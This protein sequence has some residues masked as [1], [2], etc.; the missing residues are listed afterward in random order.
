M[1]DYTIRESIPEDSPQLASLWCNIFGDPPEL[2]KSFLRLLPDMGHCCVAE[3]AGCVLGAAYLV[4]GFTLLEP[5][6]IPRRCGYLYAVAVKPDFRDM[7]IGASVSCGA[8]SL[9]RLHGAELL[10]TLPA[11]ASLYRWYDDILS[12]QYRITRTRW[13]C[14]CLPDNSKPL[15]AAVYMQKREQILHNLPHVA[16]SPAVLTFQQMLCEAYGGSLFTADGCI[17]CAYREGTRWLIPELLIEKGSHRMP[18]GLV[19]ESLPYIC[20]VSPLPEGLVWNLTFD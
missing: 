9:G 14:D 18:E 6:R 2:V 10:C 20:S 19:A 4:D 17:F 16:V 8:A 11:E 5:D 15:P 7:G 3:S 12:M 1:G 13:Y